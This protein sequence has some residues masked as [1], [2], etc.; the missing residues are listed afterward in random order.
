MTSVG[1]TDNSIRR[2]M[3]AQCEPVRLRA[4]ITMDIEAGDYVD[5]QQVK[6]SIEALFTEIRQ[7]HESAL[8]EFKQRRPRAKPRPAAPG[9]IIVTYADD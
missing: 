8:L 5:A 1:V 2:R 4:T 6:A 7:R 9:P 3:H